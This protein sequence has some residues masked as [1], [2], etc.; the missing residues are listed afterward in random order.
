MSETPETTEPA[1]RPRRRVGWFVSLFVFLLI[2]VATVAGGGFVMLHRAYTDPGPLAAD[3]VLVIP[4]GSVLWV[5]A[6]G[7]AA[8]ASRHLQ[9]VQYFLYW[10][11]RN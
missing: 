9:T 8:G 4:P 10:L 5:G 7:H 1:P 11:R 2:A 3:T 6:Y